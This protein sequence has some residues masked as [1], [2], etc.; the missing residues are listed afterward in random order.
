MMDNI[1]SIEKLIYHSRPI[2]CCAYQV[3]MGLS[4]SM[5]HLGPELCGLS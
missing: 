1:A 3:G 5:K 2:L 4:V